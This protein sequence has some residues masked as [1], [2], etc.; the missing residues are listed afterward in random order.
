L[1]LISVCIEENCKPPWNS[2]FP[3]V[4]F[5]VGNR[6]APGGT[7]SSQCFRPR[8][9]QDESEP[10]GTVSESTLMRQLELER[11]LEAGSHGLLLPEPGGVRSILPPSS[12]ISKLPS[13]IWNTVTGLRHH[14]KNRGK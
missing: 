11:G 8:I 9:L 7:M 13:V 4:V 2:R 10:I 5:W 14:P 12:E 6:K 3:V 1:I